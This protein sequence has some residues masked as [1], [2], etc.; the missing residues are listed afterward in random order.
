MIII[1]YKIPLNLP[2]EKGDFPDFAFF[3]GLRGLYKR[4]FK[5]VLGGINCIINYQM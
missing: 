5:T 2:L 3:K 1:Y 4:F